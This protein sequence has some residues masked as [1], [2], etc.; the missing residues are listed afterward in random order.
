MFG[1]WFVERKPNILQRFVCKRF[2]EKCICE[3]IPKNI[4]Y[5]FYISCDFSVLF[6]LPKFA[7]SQ[8]GLR[9]EYFFLLRYK[10]Y[11]E[12][13]WVDKINITSAKAN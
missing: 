7:H 6:I 2:Y 4:E 5:T 1:Q 12:N 11:L 9:L 3:F 8:L 10:S 13:K